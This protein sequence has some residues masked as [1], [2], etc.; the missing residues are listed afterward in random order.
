MALLILPVSG[1]F[2]ASEKE[3]DAI[4]DA[5]I[6]AG[7]GAPVADS[8]CVAAGDAAADQT[9]RGALPMIYPTCAFIIEDPNG[10]DAYALAVVKK[11]TALSLYTRRVY[12]AEYAASGAEKT[13]LRDTFLSASFR[14]LRRGS[15]RAA[16]R[17]H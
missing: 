3:E 10:D 7:V 13:K 11:M 9:M 6:C 14:W 12:I 17:R 8:N 2:A 15:K 16:G 5:L 1:A 4:K